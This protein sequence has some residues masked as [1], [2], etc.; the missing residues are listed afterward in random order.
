MLAILLT[1]FQIPHGNRAYMER[2]Q[3]SVMPGYPGLSRDWPPLFT[4]V[5]DDHDYRRQYEWWHF[6]EPFIPSWFTFYTVAFDSEITLIWNKMLPPACVA[7]S[8]LVPKRMELERESCISHS[9]LRSL[10][11]KNGGFEFLHILTTCLPE[12][13]VLDERL[14]SPKQAQKHRFTT[15]RWK[16]GEVH[17]FNW[18]S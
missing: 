6:S 16:E 4:V 15:G 5:I 8:F 14:G 17:P 11:S 10:S 18:D 1:L 7:V 3:P 13:A 9:S 2:M 12:T